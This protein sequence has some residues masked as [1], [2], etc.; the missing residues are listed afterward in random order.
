MQIGPYRVLKLLGRGASGRVFLAEHKDLCHRVAIKVLSVEKETVISCTDLPAR[1]KRLTRFVREGRTLAHL[2]RAGHSGIVRVIDCRRNKKRTRAY[3]VMEYIH[4]VPL[5]ELIS[6]RVLLQDA[7]EIAIQIAEA[8]AFVHKHNIVHRDVKPENILVRS[9]NAS[10]G[11]AANGAQ[12]GKEEV[13]LV[14]F[15][16]AA[17]PALVGSNDEGVAARS[18]Q[19][20]TTKEGTLLGTIGYMAPEQCKGLRATDRSDVYALG[21]VL[22]ELLSGERPFS[23][24]TAIELLLQCTE[25]DPPALGSFAA[26]RG[27]SVPH[28][29]SELVASMLDRDP[30]QRPSMASV[31]SS[32]RAPPAIEACPLPGLAALHADDA[33]LLIGRNQEANLIAEWIRTRTTDAWKEAESSSR[34]IVVEG[35]AG[36]GKTSLVQAGVL[37]LLERR[38]S[39]GGWSIDAIAPTAQAITE[40]LRTYGKAMPRPA[41]LFID[42]VERVL[43]GSDAE[44][45]RWADALAQVLALPGP[46]VV[47]TAVRRDALGRLLGL[48]ALRTFGRDVLDLAPLS[49][50]LLGEVVSAICRRGRIRPSE[51]VRE[52]V[53]KDTSTANIPL[54]FIQLFF[55]LLWQRR[56]SGTLYLTEYE[57]RVG[58]T[59][60]VRF[61]A[62]TIER[63]LER[64]GE[65][66]RECT[67]RILVA[68]V[69]PGRGLP[70]TRRVRSREDLVRAAGSKAAEAVLRQLTG[71]GPIVL[72][73]PPLLV[74]CAGPELDAMTLVHEAVLTEVPLIA[75]WIAAERPSLEYLVH[76]EERAT[77]WER[78]GKPAADLPQGTLLR[79]YTLWRERLN[80][81]STLLAQ[82]FITSAQAAEKRRRWQRRWLTAAL[83]MGVFAILLIASFAG[84]QQRRADLSA[85]RANEHL[86]QVLSSVEQIAT[87]T[88]WD[89]AVLP[90]PSGRLFD[91]RRGLLEAAETRLREIRDEELARPGVR[92]ARIRVRQRLAD[93]AF[94]HIRLDVAAHWLQAA[95]QDIEAG[96]RGAQEQRE[97]RLL[98]ALH[99]SKAGKIAQARGQRDVALGDFVRSLDELRQLRANSGRSDTASGTDLLLSLA[100]SSLEL[101]AAR[102]DEWS[103][104][105]EQQAGRQLLQDSLALYEQAGT[106]PYQQG[107]AADAELQLGD[108]ALRQG[109]LFEAEARLDHASA[110]YRRLLRDT[111]T[112]MGWRAAMLRVQRLR[113]RLF[114]AQKRLEADGEALEESATAGRALLQDQPAEWKHRGQLLAAI[115]ILVELYKYQSNFRLPAAN[116]LRSEI[117]GMVLPMLRTDP[118]PIRP[119][120]IRDEVCVGAEASL[121]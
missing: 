65:H 21:V 38:P 57:Q 2:T 34:W 28:W 48:P 53:V 114:A 94:W 116:Q 74:S 79:Q 117:C 55:R 88:D 44:A 14:D 69:W 10:A 15:G 106:M 105:A 40:W 118:E 89:L 52:R 11:D 13:I 90:D 101:G 45:S 115:E 17:A 75:G 113:A 68:L 24:Q 20:L 76:L 91:V 100:T 81:A 86:Q 1:T 49:S 87:D 19:N 83:S 3:L 23:G 119:I 39:P 35:I 46:V 37:P 120:H 51:G 66:E 109:S 96:L 80:Q 63:D 92:I 30:A 43:A 62:D 111:P 32:L 77:E 26:Q 12:V 107:L 8:L 18:L 112:H 27:I 97:L 110:T 78:Q 82:E 42:H 67:R 54:V 108:L 58:T 64:L 59:G 103:S 73:G 5:R 47:L 84:W 99:W 6:R 71:E 93:L 9:V 70:D 31:V 7:L 72:D 60:L 95:H 98:A 41:L 4:G 29:V 50:A 56:G 16:I 22:F 61:L 25:H 85:Q 102:S 104:P 121:R 33:E 36:V